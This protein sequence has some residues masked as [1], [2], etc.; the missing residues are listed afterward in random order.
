MSV[1]ATDLTRAI[2]GAGI[3]GRPVCLHSSLSSFGWV[4]GG[5]GTVVDAFLECGVTLLVPTFSWEAF[6]VVPPPPDMRLPRNG[7]DYSRMA[8]KDSGRVFSTANDD[9]DRSMGAIPAA[10]LGHPGRRR[11]DHPLCSFAAVGPEAARLTGGQTAIDVYAPLAVLAQS[12]GVVVLAGVGMDRM[13]LLHY[14]EEVA[15]RALF[16]RWARGVHGDIEMVTVG[17]CSGGFDRFA[18]LL[19][20]VETRVRV[21]DSAWRVFPAQAAIRIAAAAIERDPTITSCGDPECERCADI[22]A[23]G[24]VI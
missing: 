10:L 3:L 9:I 12:G 2:T 23:G 1:T 19:E 8:A 18:G 6:A 7:T 20:A 14:A 13:T 24:P 11:G 21:G 16:R 17:G 4:D 15:G 5:A 22:V